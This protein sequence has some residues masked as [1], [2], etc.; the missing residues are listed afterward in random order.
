MGAAPAPETPTF[1]PSA[2]IVPTLSLNGPASI[3]ISANQV[4]AV[5]RCHSYNPL[6]FPSD[7]ALNFYFVCIYSAI[8]TL[9]GNVYNQL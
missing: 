8:R 5:V 3:S 9:H 6:T 1:P 7:I 4:R 2:S